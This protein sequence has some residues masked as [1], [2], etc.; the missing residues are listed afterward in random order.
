M[1]RYDHLVFFPFRN[2]VEEFYNLLRPKLSFYNMLILT[3]CTISW[4]VTIFLASILSA[5][6]NNISTV[7]LGV[8]I[9]VTIVIALISSI[10]NW[11]AINRLHDLYVVNIKGAFKVYYDHEFVP[12]DEQHIQ[13]YIPED[14]FEEDLLF[15]N[16]PK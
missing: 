11:I 9:G 6:Y 13:E 15:G 8:F 2:R 3:S 1:S 4:M 10:L 7:D 12:H 14:Q 16:G 5:T